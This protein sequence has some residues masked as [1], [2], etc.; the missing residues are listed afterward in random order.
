LKQLVLEWIDRQN[1]TA[2]TLEDP[3]VRIDRYE[4]VAV[5]RV[6]AILR[7]VSLDEAE[8][9]RLWKKAEDMD[10]G[11]D[12][13]HLATPLYPAL[14]AV[15]PLRR[16]DLVDR[17][18][19][20]LVSDN[21]DVAQQAVMGS[22]LWLKSS[23]DQSDTAALGLDDVV[24]EIGI[25]I[26]GRRLAV[27]PSALEFAGWLFEHG[28]TRYRGLIAGDCDHG[29]NALLEEASYH[30]TGQVFDLPKV[31]AAAF[32]LSR[33]M[34][35]AGF[36]DRPGVRGWLSSAADDPLPE[37]RNAARPSASNVEV[38]S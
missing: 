36:V 23:A 8:L 13:A 3:F 33:A 25:A 2:S 12:G 7:L 1:L 19:R 30:R 14:A 34:D 26:A 17:L 9:D 27:L 31:R 32:A 15:Y 5:D 18:R 37:V 16:A 10:S 29:L 22:Y 4:S 11:R 21:E 6:A 24:R 35:R 38:S 28:P 20:A